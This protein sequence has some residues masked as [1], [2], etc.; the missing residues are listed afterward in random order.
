MKEL[1]KD[2]VRLN[3][4]RGL[5]H[6]EK[7]EFFKNKNWMSVIKGKMTVRKTECDFDEG[8]TSTQRYKEAQ[9][10]DALRSAN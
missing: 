4:L 8:N 10:K 3:R 9:I 2:A 5:G 6:I 7:K 1:R